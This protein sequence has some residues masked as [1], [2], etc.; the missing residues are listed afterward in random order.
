M[1]R[2][3]EKRS[4]VIERYCLKCNESFSASGKFNRVC[5]PCSH[6]NNQL[7]NSIIKYLGIS[8]AK[9]Y[10]TKAKYNGTSSR[11]PVF[12]EKIGRIPNRRR[13][14]CTWDDWIKAW[15]LQVKIEQGETDMTGQT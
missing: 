2:Y 6:E 3:K 14:L 13:V 1:A 9:F 5:G 10:Y 11:A 8:R 12:F 15:W 4:K 7:Q